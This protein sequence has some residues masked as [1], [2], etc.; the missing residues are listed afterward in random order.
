MKKIAAILLIGAMIACG[1]V[2]LAQ[3]QKYGEPHLWWEDY[4]VYYSVRAQSFD[5]QIRRQPSITEYGEIIEVQF[6]QC[7]IYADRNTREILSAVVPYADADGSNKRALCSI[8][9]MEYTFEADNAY[10][11]SLVNSP[12][13]RA[14]DFLAQLAKE[15]SYSGQYYSYTLN[16]K[17]EIYVL[18]KGHENEILKALDKAL[19]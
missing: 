13:L 12:R 6:D 4:I 14:R 18:K 15:K 1:T 19:K 2:A 11:I 3:E 10:D 9:A 7:F 17:G 5:I 8:A 16:S